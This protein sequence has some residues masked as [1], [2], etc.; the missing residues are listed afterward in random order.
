MCVG[1]SDEHVASIVQVEQCNLTDQFQRLRIKHAASMISKT[2]PMYT[3]TCTKVS[4]TPVPSLISVAKF[5]GMPMFQKNLL[6]QS[7]AHV[8]L[9]QAG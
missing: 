7:L 9:H 8:F 5:F 3:K 2:V 1:V 4:E 6:S